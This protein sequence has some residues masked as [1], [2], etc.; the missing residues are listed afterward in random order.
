MNKTVLITGAG[1]GIGLE[2][3]KLYK[4]RGDHVIGTCRTAGPE[5]DSLGIEVIDGVDVSVPGDVESLAERLGDTR[6]DVLINNAG[7]L[8]NETLDNMDTESVENQFRINALGPLRV[9]HSLLGS[10]HEGAKIA[11]I[12]SQMGSVADNGMGGYYGYRMSKS[13]LNSASRSLAI[14]LKP[15]GI[16]VAIIHPGFVQTGMTGGAGNIDAATA[17]RQI[18]ERIDELTPDN[19]GSFWHSNGEVLPW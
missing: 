7:V 10:L 9:T 17:A 1:R 16:A 11:M 18:A 2:L 4:Q 3:G 19:S 6:I 14:D 5:I 8:R 13:A 12:T 15:R